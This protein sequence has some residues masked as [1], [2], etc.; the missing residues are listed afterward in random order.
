MYHLKYSGA[1]TTEEKRSVPKA[2]WLHSCIIVKHES[3]FFLPQK[4]VNVS[5]HVTNQDL[6]MDGER[7][8]LHCVYCVLMDLTSTTCIPTFTHTHN[9]QVVRIN[10]STTLLMSLIISQ[11]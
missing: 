3:N 2:M 5:S 10:F 4:Q 1:E 7:E 6:R 11:A 8:V 9:Y